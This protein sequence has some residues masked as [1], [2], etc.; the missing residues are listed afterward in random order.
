[1]MVFDSWRLLD[2]SVWL[3]S[4]GFEVQQDYCWFWHNDSWAIKFTDPKKE[5]VAMLKW[6]EIK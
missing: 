5:L 2:I 3:S 4:I 1:M 6:K